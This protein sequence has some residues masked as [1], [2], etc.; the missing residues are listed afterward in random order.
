MVLL[1]VLSLTCILPGTAFGA[2]E[3]TIPVNISAQ[4]YDAAAQE[5]LDLVNAQRAAYGKEPLVLDSDLQEAAMTR[6]LE[7]VVYFSHTRPDGSR[8]NTAGPADMVGENLAVA[9]T[10]PE[11]VVNAWMNSDGHRAN[12]LNTKY[13]SIGIGCVYYDGIWF[14]SQAFSLSQGD[15]KVPEGITEV[16]ETIDLK[17]ELVELTWAGETKID[18][19]GG[20][21][22]SPVTAQIRGVNAGWEY[23]TFDLAP[24]LFEFRTTN[25]KILKV[26][27][28]GTM[29]PGSVGTVIFTATLKGDDQCVLVQEL[30]IV[31]TLK[32]EDV[33]LSENSYTYDGKA[34]KPEVYV[35]GL[36]EDDYVVSYKNN[37]KV[38]TATVTI[39]G[40]GDVDG[41]VT[42]TFKINH[43]RP[44]QVTL[45]KPT[46]GSSHY[47]KVKWYD[48]DCDGYQ[49]RYA[50]N[51]SFKNSKSIYVKDGDQ[52]ERTIKKLSKGKRYYVKVR[53]YNNYEDTKVFGKWSKWKSVVCK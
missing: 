42:K 5:V 13:K 8:C 27:A 29:V 4:R 14:W 2:A 44:G 15:G 46:T 10:S 52:L 21:N 22:D 35:D 41:T 50:T 39:T 51:S 17:R 19:A 25:E 53:A 11:M 12:M 16:N 37:V 49:I 48:K 31:R 9:Q 28:D 24:E 30:Q 23:M 33:S 6:A 7:S 45:K 40:V 20:E 18:L 26:N 38:G 47:V 43:D 3:G 32:A 36:T 1:L 34:K